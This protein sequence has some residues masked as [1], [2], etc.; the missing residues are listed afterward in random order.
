MESLQII[1]LNTIALKKYRIKRLNVLLLYNHESVLARCW[2]NGSKIF[3][4]NFSFD[5]K[6]IISLK[7]VF[8]WLFNDQSE[9]F[10]GKILC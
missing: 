10:E 9:H 5:Y 1:L 7:V 4:I 3:K 6:S 8:F 2:R